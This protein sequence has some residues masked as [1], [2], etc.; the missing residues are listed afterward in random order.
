MRRQELS[1]NRET[2]LLSQIEDEALK[3][4]SDLPSALRK[5]VALGGRSG[6][7]ALREWAIGELKGYVG[8][9]E[10][11]RY[12]TVGAPLA[13]SGATMNGIIDGQTIGPMSLPDGIR[14]HVKEEV[15]LRG[16]ITEIVEAVAN[17]RRKG[18]SVVRFS[19]PSGSDVATLMNHEA[20]RRDP[21]LGPTQRITSLYW[22]VH[23]SSLVGVIEAVRTTLVELVSEIRAGMPDDAAIPSKAL[24]DHAVSIAVT[25]SRNRVQ[26]TAAS[27]SGGGTAQVTSP[28]TEPEP[29]SHRMMWWVVAVFTVIGALATVAALL[30]S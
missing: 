19:L 29:A 17:A 26:V 7:E 24:T 20:T 8:A 2:S 10:L 12:R 30:L 28:S 6:S 22:E 9:S 25:G 16:P 27:S 15:P 13:I 4:E 23:T 21:F 11:P 18:D 14:E 5:C 1:R 3:G